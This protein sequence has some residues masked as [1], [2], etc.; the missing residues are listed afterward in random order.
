MSELAGAPLAD[1]VVRM[2]W[3]PGLGSAPGCVDIGWMDHGH[4]TCKLVSLAQAATLVTVI[5]YLTGDG[6]PTVE[7]VQLL[8]IAHV[9]G[10]WR[11][12][13]AED[14]EARARATSQPTEPT[15]PAAPGDPAVPVGPTGL[16]TS[17]EPIA[18]RSNGAS[19]GLPSPGQEDRD[20]VVDEH[21]RVLG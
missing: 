3:R 21:L 17:V 6:R 14:A 10:P 2:W 11:P 20:V 13:D 1:G 9:A 4:V 7:L 8:R 5:T 19:G 15:E 12:A 16:A 18:R